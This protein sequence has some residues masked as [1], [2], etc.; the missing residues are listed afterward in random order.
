MATLETNLVQP[1]TGSTLTLGASGD[2]VA[3]GTGASATGFDS[4]LASVQIFTSSGTWTKPSGIR[5]AMVEVQGAGAGGNNGQ[6][7][8]GYAT[9]GSS[10]GYVRKLID[11]SS[12]S[13]ATITIGSK[14]AGSATRVGNDGGDSVWSDGANTLTA[15]GGIASNNNYLVG[16]AGGSATGGDLN[17]QGGNGATAADGAG[18][19]LFGDGGKTYLYNATGYGAGGAYQ[20]NGTGGDGTDGIVIVTEYK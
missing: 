9:N 8:S 11:V 18:S 1:S 7:N 2:T 6:A 13:S 14:G 15:G 20:Y 3:L 16:T 4:G 12:I 10:G 5:L 17:I 19:T